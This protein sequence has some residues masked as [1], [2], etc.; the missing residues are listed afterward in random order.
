[1]KNILKRCISGIVALA[2]SLSP[3]LSAVPQ[4]PFT[5]TALADGS[6]ASGGGGTSGG[7]TG[8][9]GASSGFSESTVGYR[10]TL[11][12]SATGQRYGNSYDFLASSPS[13]DIY[14]TN[15]A[16]EGLSTGSLH[17]MSWDSLM[18]R[19]NSLLG[20]ENVHTSIPSWLSSYDGTNASSDSS[21]FKQWF[22]SS[23]AS[24]RLSGNLFANIAEA[25]A[26]SYEKFLEYF[27]DYLSMILSD[28]LAFSNKQFE[29][30]KSKSGNQSIDPNFVSFRSIG[31]SSEN[32]SSLMGKVAGYMSDNN[33]NAYLSA[34]II[35]GL[36]AVPNFRKWADE[37][38]LEAKLSSKLSYPNLT[39]DMKAVADDFALIPSLMAAGQIVS[40]KMSG[41]TEAQ[42]EANLQAAMNGGTS[43]GTQGNTGNSNSNT[44]GGKTSSSS[45]SSGTS[46]SDS[47][48]IIKEVLTQIQ[49]KQYF[50]EGDNDLGYC[51]P[52]M[53]LSP[54][55]Q[56]G[57]SETNYFGKPVGETLQLYRTNEISVLVEPIAWFYPLRYNT[58]TGKSE[59]A[60]R[61]FYGTALNWSQSGMDPSSSQCGM[62]NYRLVNGAFLT[63]MRLEDDE[64]AS[65][66]SG[67]VQ[68]RTP[69]S[70][71]GHKMLAGVPYTYEKNSGG[72]IQSNQLKALFDG[73]TGNGFHLYFAKVPP[74]YKPVAPTGSTNTTSG[75]YKVIK[76]YQKTGLLTVP[77]YRNVRSTTVPTTDTNSDYEGFAYQGYFVTSNNYNPPAEIAVGT[78]EKALAD[79]PKNTWV[80]AGTQTGGMNFDPD[81]TH[82]GRTI[83]LLYECTTS[84]DF[85]DTYDVEH[86]PNQPSGSEKHPDGS[87]KKDNPDDYLTDGNQNPGKGIIIDKHYRIKNSDNSYTTVAHFITKRAPHDIKITEEYDK[88]GF[89]LMEYHTAN[90]NW[91]IEEGHEGGTGFPS[92][93]TYEQKIIPHN[94]HQFENSYTGSGS[95]QTRIKIPANT[96]NVL[97][98]LYEKPPKEVIEQN[99]YLDEDGNP[100]RDDPEKP[101]YENEDY[102]PFKP[103]N[104]PPGFE[105]IYTKQDGGPE[106]PAPEITVQPTTRKVDVYYQKKTRA[107]FLT[108]DELSYN[109]KVSYLTFNKAAQVWDYYAG[110]DSDHRR[111]GHMKDSCTHYR[112]CS[113]H[114]SH[115]YTRTRG[116]TW[117]GFRDAAYSASVADNTDYT[118]TT[119]FLRDTQNIGYLDNRGN[120]WI[121]GKTGSSGK[122]TPLEPDLAVLLYRDKSKDAVT[123]MLNKNDGSIISEL[124]SNLGVKAPS[125]KPAG[126]RIMS[127]MGT[128]YK[129]ANFKEHFR[130][131]FAYTSHDQTITWWCKRSCSSHAWEHNESSPDSQIGASTDYANEFYTGKS[132]TNQKNVKE[133]YYVGRPNTS[134][135]SPSDD[136]SDFFGDGFKKYDSKSDGNYQAFNSQGKLSFYPYNKMIYYSPT[137]TGGNG[138]VSNVYV[139]SE[140]VSQMGLNAHVQLGLYKENP[141]NVALQSTQWSTHA[142]ALNFLKSKSITD[143]NS[144]GVGGMTQE[145]SFKD[146]GTKT[147]VGIRTWLPYVP[148]RG[149][150][151][152]SVKGNGISNNFVGEYSHASDAANKLFNDAKTS[153]KGYGL[154]QTMISGF[155][156]NTDSVINGTK[157]HN[158]TSVDFLAN[159]TNTELARAGSTSEDSK[160][161]LKWDTGSGKD[162]NGYDAKGSSRAN[163]DVLDSSSDTKLKLQLAFTIYSD[164]EGNVTL[165]MRVV[166]NNM[167]AGVSN[168]TWTITKD[169]KASDLIAKNPYLKVLDNNTK[170]ITSFVG[171]TM[172]ANGSKD[173]SIDRNQCKNDDNTTGE[174]NI[175]NYS[176]VG[177]TFNDAFDGVSYLYTFYTI[178]LGF[179]GSYPDRRT[180]IIDPLLV[181]R[182][183]SK[184]DL[185]NKDKYRTSIYRTEETPNKPAIKQSKGYVSSLPNISTIKGFDISFKNPA[186]V[187]YTKLWWLANA[188]VGDLN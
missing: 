170:M 72:V 127:S 62:G 41:M 58:T 23:N 10:I 130:T 63:A 77:M 166:K 37:N 120:P 25:S 34:N 139:V 113:E 71:N 46:G 40:A 140:N 43:T 35:S 14:Y 124:Q 21:D 1:M 13:A 59:R 2:V 101:I 82:P 7:A 121:A 91:Y 187:A 110:I 184:A 9:G 164:V 5:V 69:V 134:I 106:D 57:E 151:L 168:Q 85:I 138:G 154:V 80:Y 116:Y 3:V 147:L 135:L 148:D 118:S 19:L 38:Q 111:S 15:C 165:E 52:I 126:A 29:S 20:P 24:A 128:A 88:T 186:K 132:G 64:E 12:H 100:M 160:Y 188:T 125:Y 119:T 108:S 156:N 92:I 129:S 18:S 104:P 150:A 141:I 117:Q 174:A 146:S 122:S 45:G 55:G 27:G 177:N 172:D 183:D 73:G 155:S 102:N 105:Y 83:C 142:S 96:S 162:A 61:K 33:F 56:L 143:K 93:S 157:L 8:H 51:I 161:F 123:L 152:K 185:Y 99:H 158:K 26:L 173:G 87:P 65:A 68:G 30:F 171:N 136:S 81:G 53:C 17:A 149:E 86:N 133:Y 163:F 167:G 67:E 60:G 4:N 42:A 169:Q 79:N 179:G 109:Y 6:N 97:H 44:S 70:F 74:D 28:P 54:S 144:V 112:S 145:L 16:G 137:R 47:E 22:Q 95:I 50:P 182:A 103:E 181:Q 153:L 31:M 176:R 66:A 107:L 159:K 98:I 89:R 175:R 39:T 49:N 36:R 180:N 78:W 11:I 94:D 131:N 75:A 178:E 32:F 114:G 48:S 84:G 76:Y 90:D 115:A